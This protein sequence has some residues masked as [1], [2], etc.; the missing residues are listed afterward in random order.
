MGSTP[1]SLGAC[2]H[3]ILEKGSRLCTG[4]STQFRLYMTHVCAKPCHAMPCPAAAHIA[5]TGSGYCLLHPPFLLPSF[6]SIFH[7]NNISVNFSDVRR[8]LSHFSSFF[9]GLQWP[10][11]GVGWMRRASPKFLSLDQS[12][13]LLHGMLA[14]TFARW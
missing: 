5:I 10:M 9:H 4:R 1:T 12:L 6:I 11:I 14:K 8:A 13:K 2:Q 7:R 3:G